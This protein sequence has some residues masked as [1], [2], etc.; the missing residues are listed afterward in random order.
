MTTSRASDMTDLVIKEVTHLIEPVI[1]DM[2]FELV[3]IQYLSEHS[4]WVLK[5]YVDKEDGITLDDCARASRE[6]GDLLDVKD[7]IQNE[8]VLEVSSPGLNRPLKREKEFKR[9]VGKKV[10][11]KMITPVKGRR[12]FT[13]YL[14]SFQ[15]GILYIEVDDNLIPLAWKEVGKANLVYE[16][17]PGK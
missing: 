4:R 5:I 8:Y 7:I 15:D 10:K 13:G 16:F 6:I 11:V 3:D 1:D 2:Q 9:A 14:R 12:N 17:V